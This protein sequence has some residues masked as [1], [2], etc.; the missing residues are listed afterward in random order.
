MR[1]V[2]VNLNM[3]SRTLRRIKDQVEKDLRGRG[4]K[5]A[6]KTLATLARGADA[7]ENQVS[8]Y[9]FDEGVETRRLNTSGLQL[10]LQRNARRRVTA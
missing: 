9:L 4:W 1:K 7:A 8:D 5:P 2:G 10:R 3:D 6:E